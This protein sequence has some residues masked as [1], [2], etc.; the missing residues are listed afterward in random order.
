MESV[1][2][3]GQSNAA[4]LWD[5]AVSGLTPAANTQRWVAGTGWVAPVN[6]LITFCNWLK[7]QTNK[8]VNVLPCAVDGS[9]M[10]DW[11]DK[12]PTAPLGK[13]MTAITAS[14]SDLKGCWFIHGESDAFY[15]ITVA[16]YLSG[17]IEMHAVI[18]RTCGKK[19]ADLPFIVSPLG[20]TEHSYGYGR[21]VLTAQLLSKDYNGFRLG[22]DYYD[23]NTSD[24][25]HITATDMATFA[26]R[27][28]TAFAD[29][30]QPQWVAP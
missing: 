7:V 2:I 19:P 17:L 22:P 4:N 5:L 30:I 27:G 9:L 24:G 12:A 18:A 21:H 1:A 10:G 13:F 11:L 20:A 6:H 3:I 14:G 26:V 29:I 15:G 16:Q 23:L 25:V 8:P 28:A